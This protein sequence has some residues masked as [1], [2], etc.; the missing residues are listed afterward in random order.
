MGRN[1]AAFSSARGITMVDRQVRAVER[2]VE[3]APEGTVQLM[4]SDPPLHTQLRRLVA[5]AFTPG[6]VRALEPMVRRAVCD[7]LDAIEPGTTANVVD[8]LSAPVPIYVLAALFDV[9][10]SLWPDFRRW[11]DSM[12]Q[13]LDEVDAEKQARNFA[14]IAELFEYFAIEGEARRRE[15]RDDLLSLLANGTVDD[16][17]LTAQDFGNYCMLLLVAGNETTRNTMTGGVRALGLHP[18]Q[19]ALMIEHPERTAASTAEILRWVSPV[20]GFGRTAMRDV[21]IRDQTIA[22]GDW[23][24]LLY[25]SANRDEDVWERADT[26]DVTRPA[27]PPHVAF[28]FG[29]HMCLGAGLAALELDIV[30]E[31]LLR[32]FPSFELAGE[33]TPVPGSLV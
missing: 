32:R 15:P 4:M 3:Y 28:G 25:P 7:A 1:T 27:D 2:T 23:V 11:S 17:P 10:R 5:G 16:R 8:V 12:V 20:Q 6:A 19:R 29:P 31:E 30:F 9:P 22:A 33:H 24:L 26:F 18:D 13:Q 21:V 14:N